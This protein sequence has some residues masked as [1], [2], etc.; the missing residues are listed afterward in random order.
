MLAILSQD[1]LCSRNDPDAASSW[2][3]GRWAGAG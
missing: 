3:S 1:V 2:P